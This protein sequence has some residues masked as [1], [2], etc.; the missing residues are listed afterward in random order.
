MSP[1]LV[2]VNKL[3]SLYP[4]VWDSLVDSWLVIKIGDPQVTPRQLF[5]RIPAAFPRSSAPQILQW[6]YKWR[7][8]A[9]EKMRASGKAGMTDQQIADFVSRFMPAYQAYLPQLYAAGPTTCHKSKT[10][11]IEVDKNR[12]PVSNQPPPLGSNRRSSSLLI[13][14]ALLVGWFS[15]VHS[16]P[17]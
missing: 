10:L 9:E 12:A 2:K 15:V 13:T 14:A 3:L 1:D 11:V 5:L 6:V 8:Q 7:L 4:V 17:S 16:S